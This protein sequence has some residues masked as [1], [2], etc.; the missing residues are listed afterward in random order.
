MRSYLPLVP[1][2]FALAAPCAF[3]VESTDLIGPRNVG[4]G[5]SVVASVNDATAQYL[6]PAALGFMWRKSEMNDNNKLDDKVFGWNLADASGRVTT[7]GQLANRLEELA[8]IDFEQLKET[9]SNLNPA[10][11]KDLLS[12]LAQLSAIADKKESLLFS[13]T[14][15]SQMRIG[16]FAI[17]VRGFG[18]AFANVHSIDRVNLGLDLTGASQ[19]NIREALNSTA[20]SDT[21]FTRV[22]PDYVPSVL[23]D[24]QQTSL[25]TALAAIPNLAGE[26]T[27]QRDAKVA[28]A[29]N[30]TDYQL[31]LLI[32]SG[33]VSA[34]DVQGAVDLLVSTVNATKGSL[35]TST[36]LRNNTTAVAI[37]GFGLLEIPVSYG[38]APNDWLSF[39]VTGKLMHGTVMGTNVF[40]F[41]EDNDKVMKNIQDNNQQTLNWGVDAS[42]M[43]RLPMLQAAIVGRN[44]NEPKF[45]GLTTPM[46]VNGN[47]QNVVMDDVTVNRQ[48][49][50]G[51]AFIPW[52]RF[53]I[54]GRYDLLK[55]DTMAPNWSEQRA[56]VGAELDLWFL[57]L[58]AG[59]G[60]NL[61][62]KD[63]HPFYSAGLGLNFW[64]MRIDFGVGADSEWIKNYKDVIKEK[65]LPGEAMASV[66]IAIDF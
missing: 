49:T 2:L 44:L 61:S 53:T 50:V 57:A 59:M 23:T 45:K 17:G 19:D 26:T 34:S 65:D 36:E 31:S 58:R 48:V 16:S 39:G 27:A 35:G 5:G 38:Y 1:S 12:A 42:I 4:M 54:E 11:A 7:T 6:N 40:V 56:S 46:L 41:D 33:R 43:V 14:A 37:R 64:L 28:N 3:A 24:A 66:G 15:G 20:V 62:E 13:G 18:E 51:A 8:N 47:T 21:A 9:N 55:V 32:A 29:L 60:K 10:M 30:Y 22:S 25:R 63:S 52:S